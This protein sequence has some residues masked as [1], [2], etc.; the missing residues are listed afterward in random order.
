MKTNKS[1]I[2]R[3]K[4]SKNGKITGRTKGQNHFNAKGSGNVVRRKHNTVAIV[5]KNKDRGRYLSNA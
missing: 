4:V 5:M 2:K 1:Y 3:F